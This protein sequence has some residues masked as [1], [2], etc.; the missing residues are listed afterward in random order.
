MVSHVLAPLSSKLFLRGFSDEAVTAKGFFSKSKKLSVGHVRSIQDARISYGFK[1]PL[2][3][4]ESFKL[5]LVSSVKLE[6]SLPWL[7]LV[8]PCKAF[9]IQKTISP[10]GLH[11]ATADLSA[12]KPAAEP[13]VKKTIKKNRAMTG[14]LLGGRSSGQ[15]N[16]GLKYVFERELRVAPK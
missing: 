12:S 6:P 7:N 3:L 2:A 13:R 1:I 9:K 10:V 14:Y 11:I 16:S 4:G 15:I 5:R 8:C